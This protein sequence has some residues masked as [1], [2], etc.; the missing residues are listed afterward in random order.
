MQTAV[1][2]T[3]HSARAVQRWPSERPL[4]ALVLL[5]SLALWLMLAVTIIGFIYAG[6]IGFA[7]FVGHVIMISHLRGS[8]VRLGPE[9]MPE[10]YARVREIAAQLGMGQVPDAYV[11]QQGGSLNAF[12]TK[13]F[14]TSFIVLYS[15]L[16]EACGDNQEARDFIIAHELGHLAAGHL[17][18]RWLILPGLFVPFLGTAYSRACEYTSDRYGISVARDREAA[19]DGLTILAAGAK[20]GPRVNRRALVAQRADMQKVLMKIGAWLSTHPPIADRLATLAPQLSDR[21]VG[22]GASLRAALLLA[23]LALLPFAFVGALF[24]L[25]PSGGF[26]AQK[27]TSNNALAASMFGDTAFADQ[28]PS[29]DHDADPTLDVDAAMTQIHADITALA[30]IAEAHHER[31]GAAPQSPEHLYKLFIAAKPDAAQ[32]GDPF[33][34]G[35]PYGYRVLDD[36]RFM[37]WSVGPDA[38]SEDDDPYYIGPSDEEEEEEEDSE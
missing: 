23:V 27:L 5:V 1:A 4:F 19:L 32:P 31:T 14:G 37:L 17:R 3:P 36:G 21:P 2:T 11:L 38:D 20:H 29:D 12:A 26:F 16:L 6:L 25:L 30:A 28:L 24:T 33:N 34:D 8:A 9:Q 22:A 15:D 7:F 18:G 35:L 10:L 13:F